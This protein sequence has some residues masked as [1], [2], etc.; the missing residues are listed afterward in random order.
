MLSRRKDELE[1]RITSL[2]TEYEELL[3][4]Y[5]VPSARFILTNNLAE[6]TINDE[7]TSNVDVAEAMSD[8][9]VWGGRFV[10]PS[11]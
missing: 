4:M 7:E 1:N 9:K 3:G 5:S 10:M 2:E 8:L 11:R 6:K